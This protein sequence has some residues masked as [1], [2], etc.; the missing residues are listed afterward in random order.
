MARSPRGATISTRPAS[1]PRPPEGPMAARR[2]LLML[3]ALLLGG[4]APGV[5]GIVQDA[6]SGR[7]LAGAK[8]ELSNRGWGSRDG[9]IVWDAEQVART[10]TDGD[11]RFAF[12][13]NGGV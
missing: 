13:E 10:T 6:S 11:G 9:Q 3:A 5:S 12:G 4:C 1:L 7:P 2:S 8:V